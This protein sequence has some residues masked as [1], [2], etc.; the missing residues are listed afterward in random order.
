[1]RFLKG[2]LMASIIVVFFSFTFIANAR[3]I[4]ISPKKGDVWFEG[5][6]YTIKWRGLK[7]G[8]ICIAVLIGGHYAG[9]INDCDSCASQGTFKW[10]IPKAFVSGFGEDSDNYVRVVLYYKDNETKNYYSDYFTISK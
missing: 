9:I 5:K 8:V 2:I 4:V 10:K 7:E 6:T 1:M 3:D